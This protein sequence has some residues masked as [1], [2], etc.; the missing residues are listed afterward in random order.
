MNPVNDMPP[1]S[2]V[3][4][5]HNAATFLDESIRSI[6][7]QSFSDFEFVILDDASSDKS[8]D[9]LKRWAQHD[10]RIRLFRSDQQLGLAGSSNRVVSQTRAPI[11]AR[12]DADDVSHPERFA[13]QLEVLK[14]SGD[15]VAV[16]TL[17]NGIDSAGRV[18]RPRDRWRLRH[19]PHFIPFP[20]GSAMFRRTAYDAIGGYQ[21]LMVGED[22]DFFL[23]LTRV[24]R[25]VTLPAALYHFRYHMSNTTLLMEPTGNLAAH[26]FRQ[27]GDELATIYLRGAMRLW[28]GQSPNVVSRLIA[29]EALG[30]DFRSAGFL[31]WAL[32]GSASPAALRFLM[33]L[34][35]RTRDGMSSFKIANG[36][37]YDWRPRWPRKDSSLGR[38]DNPATKLNLGETSTS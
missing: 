16:G 38:H 23:K 30:W 11:V 29:S 26:N 9:L 25:V 17:F 15:V 33:R 18:I 1:L 21:D 13:R 31:V 2:V 4:P 27:H 35:I 7:N 6:L 36:S 32:S 20:H 10:S 34:L 5:V 28:S 12:M 8:P 19:S 14:S 3:M 22:Q 37:P 24:G